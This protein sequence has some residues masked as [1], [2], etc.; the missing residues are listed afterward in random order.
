[1]PHCFPYIFLLAAGK[2]VR[3]SGTAAHLTFS[4]SASGIPHLL[5]F[6]CLLGFKKQDFK[7]IRTDLSDAAKKPPQ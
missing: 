5:L 6:C 1:L 4:G 2:C 7:N 3:H